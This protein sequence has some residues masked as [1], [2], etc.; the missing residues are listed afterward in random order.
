MEKAAADPELRRALRR[1]AWNA[2]LAVRR[3]L[4]RAPLAELAREVREAKRRVLENLDYYIEEARRS[5]ERNG[6]RVHLASTGEDALEAIASIVGSGKTVVL[7]KTMTGEEIGLREHLEKLG[8]RVYETDLGQLLVQL[9]AGT[10]SHIIAPAV[11][12]SRRRAARLVAEKLGAPVDAEAA[13][14]EIVAAVREK[15]RSIFTGADVGVTGANAVAADTGS[16]VMVENEGN[17][18]LVSGLPPVHIA[19]VGVEKI[20]P[21]LLDAVKAAMVQAGYAGLYPPTYINIVSG[22]SSTADIEHHRVPG[23]H[24]P[25]ELHV[26]LLDNGRR[27]ALRDPL[28]SEALRCVRCGRCLFECPVW[29]QAG[30]AWGGRAYKGPMGL[31]WTAITESEELAG[32]LAY[33]CTQCRA[34]DAACPMEIPLT[35]II[36]GLRARH[37]S[38]L[39]GWNPRPS[40]PAPGAAPDSQ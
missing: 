27:R 13:P 39:L 38:K 4:E 6:A 8:N 20:M 25:R 15:L 26:V 12:I 36:H 29:S 16:L 32:E 35:R 1:A 40:L 2:R 5:L 37:A 19:L 22:P 21:T 9:E 10:P 14:E 3:A 30:P 28:L 33:A 34:C 11:H 31:A 18:R 24:G 17:I 23:A 7:S